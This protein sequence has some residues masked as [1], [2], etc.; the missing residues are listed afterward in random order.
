[1]LF[2]DLKL[3]D[4]EPIYI[5]IKNYIDIM[6]NK[7]LIPNNSK[8]P[9]TRELSQFLNVSRNS[10]ISAYEELKADGTI[11]SVSGKG[12]FVNH[13]NTTSNNSWNID[14]ESFE[15]EYSKIANEMDIVKNEIPWRSDLV[16]FKSI[17]P[18]GDL[19]DIDELKKSFLNRIALEGHKILNY[20]Y[21]KGYKPLIDYLLSYMNTKGV[22]TTNKDI[23]ITNGFTEGL[24]LLLSSFT[25]KGD[26]II[27]ENP[28]HNTAIKIFKSLGLNIVGID[29]NKD[30]LDFKMLEEKLYSLKNEKDI[31]IKFAYITPSYHNPTGTV[32]SPEDRYEFY[33]LMKKHNI[34][35]IEDG[36]NE[37]LL[38]SSSHIFPI[39]SLDN[40]NNGVIYIG[41]FSKILFPGL[42]IGWI[43]C[44]KNVI[45][46][47]ES[48]KRCK[49]IHV[50]FLDQAILYDYLSNGAF[51]KYVKKIKKFYGDKFN[52]AY[53]CVKKYIPNDYILGEGGLHIFIKLKNIDSRKLLNICYEKGVIFMP[54]DIFYTDD[55]GKDTLRLGISRLSLED[56][57][58]GIKIIGDSVK[59]LN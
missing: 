9:S 59:E 21:A 52:F 5:Q 48:V 12:T 16:S 4:K 13:E 53:D 41:S 29:I 50:S 24:D 20:G 3:N 43:L 51:D 37:E 28:T 38:Y 40:L 58:K 25:E 27:C 33:N 19:F 17:S 2:S 10:I 47:L 30:G 57:E 56:I 18:N 7:G 32:M 1:M 22:D 54:G 6:I 31:K 44:D 36:F 39:A 8:L 45:S 34:A 55:K 26:Y 23:L 42:R 14:F 46:R 11:Y 15:N 35:I 49:S